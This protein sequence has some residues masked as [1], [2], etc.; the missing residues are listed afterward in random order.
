MC[1]VL[2][3]GDLVRAL[4]QSRPAS[5]QEALARDRCPFDGSAVARPA[6]ARARSETHEIAANAQ[7]RPQAFRQAP[8]SLRPS[9]SAPTIISEP[10]ATNPSNPPPEPAPNG[11]TAGEERQSRTARPQ[12][13][14]PAEVDKE[15]LLATVKQISFHCRGFR[16]GEQ[17]VLRDRPTHGRRSESS[18]SVQGSKSRRRA[19]T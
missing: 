19:P 12:P 5:R 17:R 11:K 1:L 15:K 7:T 8:P 18:H 4:Q 2:V 16:C 13:E 3:L 6:S 10:P 14:K 9:P